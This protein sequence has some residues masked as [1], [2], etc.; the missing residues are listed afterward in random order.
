VRLETQETE[1]KKDFLNFEGGGKYSGCFLITKKEGEKEGSLIF[2][3]GVQGVLRKG[4]KRRSP[5]TA[6]EMQPHN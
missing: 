2:S 1:K 6:N 5:V 4:E 3:S